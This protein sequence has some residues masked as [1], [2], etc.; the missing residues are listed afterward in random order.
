MYRVSSGLHNRRHVVVVRSSISEV[1]HALV[2]AHKDA[3]RQVVRRMGL[4]NRPLIGETTM[5]NLG[6]LATYGWEHGLKVCSKT[7]WDVL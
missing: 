2:E 7:G 3:H 1:A 5:Q 4:R 6:F